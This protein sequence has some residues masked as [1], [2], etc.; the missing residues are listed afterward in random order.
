M[1][2]HWTAKA[3]EGLVQQAV[4][5]QSGCILAESLVGIWKFIARPNFCVP[6]PARQAAARWLQAAKV[7][8]DS[9]VTKMQ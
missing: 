3:T 7:Q 8:Q 1:L 6:P 4:W 9:A 5:R 2:M